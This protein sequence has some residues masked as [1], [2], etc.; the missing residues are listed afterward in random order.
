MFFLSVQQRS[1][2]PKI[3]SCVDTIERFGYSKLAL[4]T[5][6]GPA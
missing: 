5:I 4:H 3:K 6:R 2:D 1:I